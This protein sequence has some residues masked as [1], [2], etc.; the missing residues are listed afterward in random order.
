MITK[1]KS[2]NLSKIIKFILTEY[3]GEDNAQN[4]NDFDVRNRTSNNACGDE[5]DHGTETGIRGL[6]F[7]RAGNSGHR[8]LQPERNKGKHPADKGL[9]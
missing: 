8:A 2:T 7:R 3:K 9:D 5:L 4:K 6:Q 1:L